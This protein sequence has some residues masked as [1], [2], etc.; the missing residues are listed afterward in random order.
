MVHVF[1]PGSVKKLRESLGLSV[2]EFADSLELSRQIIYDLESGDCEKKPN[3]RTLE[4]IMEK[5]GANPMIFFVD[6]IS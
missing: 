6:K 2:A 1:D 3:V 5:F 4:K